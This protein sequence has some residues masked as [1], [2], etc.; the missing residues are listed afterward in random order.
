MF[1]VWKLK[2]FLLITYTEKEK[3]KSNFHSNVADL[4]KWA[5]M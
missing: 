4:L 1:Y 3:E 2:M 5:F